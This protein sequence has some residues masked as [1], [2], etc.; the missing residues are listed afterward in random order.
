MGPADMH[1]GWSKR[2]K[3]K[4]IVCRLANSSRLKKKEKRWER[5]NRKRK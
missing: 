1:A 2:K 3:N 4:K 5:K